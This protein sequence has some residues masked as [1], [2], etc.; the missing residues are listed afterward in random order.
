MSKA[1]MAEETFEKIYGNQT[2]QR[3]INA[4][5]QEFC[6]ENRQSLPSSKYG[7][8]EDWNVLPKYPRTRLLKSIEGQGTEG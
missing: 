3:R 7:M 1:G 5:R 2:P 6:K 8:I 4:S